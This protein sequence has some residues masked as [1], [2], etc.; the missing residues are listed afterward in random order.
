MGARQ[1]TAGKMDVERFAI[2]VR[3]KPDTHTKAAQLIAAGPPFDPAAVGLESHSVF[4][5]QESV[6]FVFE[7]REAGSVV[8]DNVDDPFRSPVFEA[9]ATF[10]DGPPR[11]ARQAY[12]WERTAA[13]TGS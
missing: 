6:A 12:H 8:S 13:A 3:L 2:I 5:A 7:G 1:S 10:L 11:I 4:L 9:W